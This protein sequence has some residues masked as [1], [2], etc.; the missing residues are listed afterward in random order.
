MRNYPNP[1]KIKMA[2][3]TEKFSSCLKVLD[4]PRGTFSKSLENQAFQA[5]GDCTEFFG[6]KF[7]FLIYFF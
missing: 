7:Y 4:V 1:Q 3:K 5:Y 6:K 2:G